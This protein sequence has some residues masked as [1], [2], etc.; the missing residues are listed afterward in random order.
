MQRR[1]KI[2]VIA[3]VAGLT[4]GATYFFRK[5][6]PTTGEAAPP[7]AQAEVDR[8]GV[9]KPAPQSHLLGEIQ[10][11]NQPA[12]N[13][14]LTPVAPATSAAPTAAMPVNPFNAH[15]GASFG[16]PPP[17]SPG[18]ATDNQFFPHVAGPS[19][20]LGASSYSGAPS[21][22]SEVLKHKIVD[23]DTLTALA[24]RYLGNANRY[25]ELYEMNRATLTSPDLLP[26]GAEIKVPARGLV[27]PPTTTEAAQPMVPLAPAG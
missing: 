25:L 20:P 17:V 10:A 24:D 11:A 8:R 1:S 27:A 21:G 13:G 18:K 2:L 4:G 7:S 5:G 26:I 6:A 14:D 12:G 15:P 16:P 22:A 19:Q 3:A 23:G 9:E